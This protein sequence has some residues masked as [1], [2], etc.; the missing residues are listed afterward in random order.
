MLHKCPK[1]SWIKLPFRYRQRQRWRLR[2]RANGMIVGFDGYYKI[3]PTDTKN[4]PSDLA[5]EEV[6][7][8]K[9]SKAFSISPNRRLVI[10]TPRC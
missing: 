8:S 5:P 10:P 3:Y 2:F 9:N 6:V 7:N 4:D 1:P